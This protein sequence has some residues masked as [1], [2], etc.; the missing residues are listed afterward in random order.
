MKEDIPENGD[1]DTSLKWEDTCYENGLYVIATL[2]SNTYAYSTD[3]INWTKVVYGTEKEGHI[4]CHN[5][6]IVVV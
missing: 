6:I 3:G 4:C 5:G 2:H 1:N